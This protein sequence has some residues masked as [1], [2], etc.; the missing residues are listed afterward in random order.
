M[1]LPN[2]AEV[3]AKDRLAQEK[4]FAEFLSKPTI[5]LLISILPAMESQETVRTL[6][7]EA[8]AFGWGGG[9]GATMMLLLEGLMK[10]PPS[11]SRN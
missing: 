6:L 5:R 2:E 11:S 3:Q 7:Q 9:S 1:A 10:R 8:H 4:S